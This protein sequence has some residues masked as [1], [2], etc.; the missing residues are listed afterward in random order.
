MDDRTRPATQA[1]VAYRPAEVAEL[2]DVS[3]SHVYRLIQRGQL[4]VVTLGG[5]WMV[6]SEELDRF[7]ERLKAGEAA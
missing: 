1:K 6:L 7:M 4:S 3:R 2:L 5:R